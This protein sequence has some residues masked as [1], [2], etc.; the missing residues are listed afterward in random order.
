MRDTSC[1]LESGDRVVG[2]CGLWAVS[3]PSFD[4]CRTCGRRTFRVV[5]IAS[6]MEVERKMPLCGK[7][8]LSMAIQFAELNQVETPGNLVM[9]AFD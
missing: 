4:Y 2:C 5:T 7:H 9:P 8:F 6:A 1:E 3:A